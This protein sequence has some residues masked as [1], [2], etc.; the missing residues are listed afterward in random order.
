MVNIFRDLEHNIEFTKKTIRL[1][2]P[3]KIPAIW[4]QLKLQS[5][6]AAVI[7]EN[8]GLNIIMNSHPSIK[9]KCQAKIDYL[10]SG[11]DET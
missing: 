10:C 11:V 5:N 7:A 8:A 9:A 1:S 4:I 3:S 6:H 2:K